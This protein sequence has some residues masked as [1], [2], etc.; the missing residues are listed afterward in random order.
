MTMVATITNVATAQP[1]QVL[2]LFQNAITKGYGTTSNAPAL[3]MSALNSA[4]NGP[5]SSMLPVIQSGLSHTY[6]VP[7]PIVAALTQAGKVPPSSILPLLQSAINAAYPSSGSGSGSG[8]GAYPS[9]VTLTLTIPQISSP[10]PTATLHMLETTPA[11]GIPTV[12]NPAPLSNMPLANQASLFNNLPAH[13]Q[14]SL[15]SGLIA[16]GIPS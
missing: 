12:I 14:S 11:P 3:L 8:S 15:V 13:V 7:M 4:A 10:I 2:N 5:T 1:T 16:S 6:N 9:H